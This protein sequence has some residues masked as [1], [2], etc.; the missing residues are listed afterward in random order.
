MRAI[1]CCA[2]L[3]SRAGCVSAQSAPSSFKFESVTIKP[4]KS[5]TLDNLHTES[6]TR[7]M[8][9]CESGAFGPDGCLGGPGTSDPGILRCD[10]SF[11]TLL[12]MAYQLGPLQFTPPLESSWWEIEAK[13]PAGAT[14]EQ[15]RMMEQNLLAE[16]F[17]LAVHFVK[18]EVGAYE[19]TIGKEGP[20]FKP[21]DYQIASAM[22]PRFGW[23]R[24]DGPKPGAWKAADL[25]V[26]EDH[27]WV[28]LG[29]CD[30]HHQHR[31]EQSM[32]QLALYLSSGMDRPVV[33]E[34]GLAG[35]Y[36]IM[37]DFGASPARLCGP[38]KDLVE[39]TPPPAP[40]PSLLDA[41][42]KQLGLDL[43]WTRNVVD[44]LVVDHVEKKPSKE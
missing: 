17:K 5:R 3:I 8:N 4:G 37:L 6:C 42:H 11:A 36:D 20:K 43:E 13:I 18:K 15:V 44:V 25:R 24:I 34:T 10:V 39:R 7:G 14:D 29:D 12:T 41:V 31:G 30:G 21:W 28:E 2:V 40:D 33:D 38:T 23:V 1:L 27:V 16:R 32:K 22:R 9:A 35:T 19:M 26:P